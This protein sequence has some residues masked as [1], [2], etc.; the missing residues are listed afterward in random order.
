MTLD[1]FMDA[2]SKTPRDWTIQSDGAIRQ[3]RCCP[4]EVVAGTGE[5]SSMDAFMAL[6][7]PSD[8]ADEIIWAADCDSDADRELR[9][10]LL[11]ACGL[12][13]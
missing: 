2:L 3:K 7:I 13:E 12:A 9:R 5:A 11:Q 6:E 1:E 10:R 8:I 4:L